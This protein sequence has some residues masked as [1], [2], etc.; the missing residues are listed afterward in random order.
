MNHTFFQVA[1]LQSLVLGYT[2]PVLSVRE[3]LSHG[4][5]GLGTY[6]NVDGEL[7]ALDGVCYRAHR[8][9]H[10]SVADAGDR[11]PF[12]VCS[13]L[14]GD[15]VSEL[16]DISD[17]DRL[18]RILND[19]IDADAARNGMHLI[20]LDGEFEKVRA[21][22]L[23]PYVS[24]HVKLTEILKATQKEF[25]FSPVRGTLVGVYFPECM[26]NINAPGWHMHFVSEDRTQGGHVFDLSL[27]R[28]TLRHDRVSGFEMMLPS[29]PA[30]DTYHFDQN[31]SNEIK[32]VE[33]PTDFTV[34]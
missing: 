11:I 3:F 24:E 18:L 6:E 4:D 23:G 22:S 26:Q 27:I 1:T 19:S 16:A 25:V 21:R 30:Y 12:A 29:D 9:G 14:H 28:G 10:V 7:I 34:K 8:D 17:M 33:Q 32:A 13:K 2:K 5:T 15:S 20:R 31:N